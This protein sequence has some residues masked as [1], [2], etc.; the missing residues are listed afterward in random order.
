MKKT[1]TSTETRSSSSE[2][3]HSSSSSSQ[4]QEKTPL[5]LSVSTPLTQGPDDDEPSQ[6]E[7]QSAFSF[8]EW[9][10]SSSL[11]VFLYISWVS[12]YHKCRACK[13]ERQSW[14][15]PSP[16]LAIDVW[17]RVVLCG[18]VFEK[19]GLI[20]LWSTDFWTGPDLIPHSWSKWPW[21]RICCMSRTHISWV[22]LREAWHHALTGT[23]APVTALSHPFRLKKNGRK[24]Y[25]LYSKKKIRFIIYVLNY[26]HG[27]MVK[28]VIFGE[29]LCKLSC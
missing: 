21:I 14:N 9:A 8:S 4:S 17:C 20:P 13:Q 2:S 25:F 3:T 15:H 19:K 29:C 1:S 6:S 5:Q 26:S 16:S 7:P 24:G 28:S 27:P 18:G 11:C 12:L 22:S 10:V 23:N